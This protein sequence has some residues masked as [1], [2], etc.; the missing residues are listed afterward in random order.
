MLLPCRQDYDGLGARIIHSATLKDRTVS[1]SQ[2]GGS[3][4]GKH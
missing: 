4:H 3:V 1:A 2:L